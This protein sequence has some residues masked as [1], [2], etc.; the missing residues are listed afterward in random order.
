MWIIKDWAGNEPTF[1]VSPKERT[2]KSFD[3]AEE[4]LS[5]WFEENSLDY[6][7]ERQEYDIIKKED[8]ND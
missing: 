4:F 8:T 1:H 3:D 5:N 2:F 6:E 7:V